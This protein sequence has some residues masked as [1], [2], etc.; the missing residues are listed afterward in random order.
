MAII[1]IQ[2]SPICAVIINGTHFRWDFPILPLLPPG[3]PKDTV[4]TLVYLPTSNAHLPWHRGKLTGRGV[5]LKVYCHQ[6]I[7]VL[8]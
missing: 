8:P 3:R 5:R 6:A 2:Q 1:V 7:I 4:Y